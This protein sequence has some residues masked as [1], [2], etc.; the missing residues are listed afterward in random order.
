MQALQ[1]V[2]PAFGLEFR[3]VASPDAPAPGE[4]IIAV[5]AA[6]ICGTDLHIYEWTAGYE[7]M[8]RA[9]PVTLGH[10]FSGT[11]AAVGTGVKDVRE[12]A[13]VA[14]RPSVVCGR[15]ATCLA[16]NDEACT[17]RTGIGVT[18]DGALARRVRVPAENCVAAAPGLD[19]EIVALTEP[20]TVSAEAVDTGA[21]H[22]GDRVLVLDFGRVIAQGVPAEAQ[23]DPNVIRRRIRRRA[24]MQIDVPG[25]IREPI[26][27][28][29]RSGRS[30]KQ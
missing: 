25:R 26:G 17:Q 18:R 23:A 20:M 29:G 30:G 28:C 10:E 15:C 4:V 22:T 3:E 24:D 12:G 9:M 2:A 1:K 16:G 27:E 13:V 6:G 19:A 21:V 8:T 7:A 5:S 14:V 11:V